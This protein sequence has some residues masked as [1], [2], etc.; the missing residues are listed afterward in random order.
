MSTTKE[1]HKKYMAG[2]K[3]LKLVENYFINIMEG[4]CLLLTV[5]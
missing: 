5:F 3:E 2:K 4:F 1:G